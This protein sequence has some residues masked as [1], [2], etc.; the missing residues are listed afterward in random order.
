VTGVN[1]SMD[2]VKNGHNEHVRVLS[3]ADDKY[4]NIDQAVH[5]SNRAQRFEYIRG[6]QTIKAEWSDD[7]PYQV[8]RLPS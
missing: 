3:Y 5:G 1:A 8:R 2:S 4:V 6:K 7:Y